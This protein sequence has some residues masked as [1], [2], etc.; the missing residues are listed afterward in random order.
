MSVSNL[1]AALQ[2]VVGA[3]HVLTDE[4]DTAYYRT[5][6]RYGFGGAAAVGFPGSLLE[7]WRVLQACVDA[8]AAILM[9]GTKTGLTGGSGPSGFD[10]DRPLV[11]VIS[12]RL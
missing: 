3:K 9:Q 2:S 8:G 5:G 1:I 7:Q 10:Y 11:I 6:F 4:G 12:L